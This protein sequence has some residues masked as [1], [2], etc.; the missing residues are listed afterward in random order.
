[1]LLRLCTDHLSIEYFDNWMDGVP[2][3]AG[4]LENKKGEKPIRVFTA[5][6]FQFIQLG[7]ISS[8]W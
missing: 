6:R 7:V 3:G 8:N 1:M 2:L 5:V 4:F